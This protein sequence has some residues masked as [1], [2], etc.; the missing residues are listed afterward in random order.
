MRIAVASEDEKTIAGHT[1]RCH[2]FA[3]FDI[4]D[5]QASHRVYRE[6][7]FT[8]HAHGE[9]PGEHGD[10][11]HGSH[12]PLLSALG[13]CCAVITRGMGPRLVADLAAQGI[14][15]YVCKTASVDEAVREFA[16]GR[17]QRLEDGGCCH[18]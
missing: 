6:N 11:R 3:I 8:R 12:G 17:L 18:R 16:A 9:R 14:D 13:D 15:A 7:A 1:G 5:G 2:G 4:V 10:S